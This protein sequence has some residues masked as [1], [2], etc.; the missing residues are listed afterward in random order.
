MKVTNPTDN[1]IKVIIEGEEY[2]V[3]AGKT[4]RGVPEK[5]AKYWVERLHSFLELGSEDKKTPS[6][7]IKED[8]EDKEEKEQKKDESSIIKIAKAKGIDVEE[9]DSIEE[10]KEAISAK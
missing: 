6:K 3:A 1:D 7:S 9:Y 5:H 10:I 2:E 4:L 8:K